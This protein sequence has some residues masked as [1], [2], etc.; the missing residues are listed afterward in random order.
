MSGKTGEAFQKIRVLLRRN[1]GRLINFLSLG[2]LRATDALVQL[3]LIPIIIER[4]G[5]HNYGIIA[6]VQV[7]LNYGKT[8]I[9]YGFMVTG[10]REIALAGSDKEQ[11]TF[12]F[13]K[14]FF[15]KL[16]LAFLFVG[17]L[18]LL[19][20]L[21]P[22]FHEKAI[23]FYW[24]VFI[25]L[26][27]LVFFDWF[28]IGLQRAQGIAAAN[29]ISRICFAILILT[30]VR[31]TQ[32]FPYVLACQGMAELV[33]GG[34]LLAIIKR[35]YLADRF[36]FPGLKTILQ[37]LRKDFSL[38][39]TNFILEFNA[40]SGII[41]LGFFT[42][43]VLTGIFTVMYKLVQP[44]RILLVVF[45]QAIFPVVC[46]KVEESWRTATRFLYR[47]FLYFVGSFLIGSLALYFFAGPLLEY[48]AGAGAIVY[49]WSFRL[50]LVGPFI[51]LFNIPAVQLLLACDRKKEYAA[52]HVLS[53]IIKVTL[54]LWLI[55][56]LQI[57]GAIVSVIVVELLITCGLYFMLLKFKNQSN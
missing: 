15:T 21:I 25:L 44:L 23:V 45:S 40:T 24:G 57:R 16:I 36:T 20:Y 33:V 53:F 47:S 7:W 14:V 49:T 4:V 17:L 56:W 46:Q 28:F 13:W 37:M 48:F 5:M 1:L 52:I 27:N 51:I 22:V 54:D 43:N 32:D 39:Y 3:L 19:V 29:L 11:L 18:F 41:M 30:L 38:L 55:N 34:V 50:F 26:G 31:D 12:L 10:V 35:Y 2:F 42:T 9:N 8:I 6:F